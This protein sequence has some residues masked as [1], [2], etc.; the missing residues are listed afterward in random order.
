MPEI[1]AAEECANYFLLQEVLKMLIAP[2]D[3]FNQTFYLP[4]VTFLAKK[5]TSDM[6]VSTASAL[7]L[8]LSNLPLSP[9][10]FPMSAPICVKASGGQ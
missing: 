5:S 2:C 7:S 1:A 8:S 4:L 9:S 3:T 10:V 6:N